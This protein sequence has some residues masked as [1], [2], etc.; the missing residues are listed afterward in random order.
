MATENKPFDQLN[1]ALETLFENYDKLQESLESLSKNVFNMAMD[2]R[3]Q[4][5]K[6]SVL[7]KTTRYN[8]DWYLESLEKM[9]R[10]MVDAHLETCK[11]QAITA[12]YTMDTTLHPQVETENAD[13]ILKA[14]ESVIEILKGQEKN[15]QQSDA[16]IEKVIEKATNSA[17]S[18]IKDVTLR[19]LHYIKDEMKKAVDDSTVVVNSS[20]LE[21]ELQKV[22]ASIAEAKNSYSENISAL[23]KIIPMINELSGKE[24]TGDT[25]SSLKSN[26]ETLGETVKEK[27]QKL[28]SIQAWLEVDRYPVAW[29]FRARV[30]LCMGRTRMYPLHICDHMCT[31]SFNFLFFC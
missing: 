27:L 19:L 7:G 2:A 23:D 8:L 28:S 13:K 29:T 10:A 4:A 12:R 11:S 14:L 25:L 30:L 21:K 20:V 31:T 1:D 3:D 24:N 5:V 17:G 26:A 15:R 18:I 22:K 9:S 16:D 6:I